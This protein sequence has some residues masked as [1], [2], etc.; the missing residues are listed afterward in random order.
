MHTG[1]SS[2]QYCGRW[3]RCDLNPLS[4][5]PPLNTEVNVFSK[6][7]VIAT[8]TEE[9]NAW[10]KEGHGSE[11]MVSQLSSI[12]C[13]KVPDIMIFLYR[14]TIGNHLPLHTN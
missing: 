3:F 14:C 6:L 7:S 2:S 8:D 13:S 12:L 4:Y 5:P 9:Q 10:R 1:L 11:V